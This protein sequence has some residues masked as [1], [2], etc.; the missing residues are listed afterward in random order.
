MMLQQNAFTLTVVSA[1]KGEFYSTLPYLTTM[2]VQNS[3][4]LSF[5][6]DYTQTLSGFGF[7][8]DVLVSGSYHYKGEICIT[9][10][11][12]DSA[13]GDFDLIAEGTSTFDDG[14]D[15]VTVTLTYTGFLQ[16]HRTQ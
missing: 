4:D 6:I 7:G 10:T 12:D 11:D 2:V 16:G 14:E 3:G 5:P 8:E 15:P 9:R 13:I 1:R